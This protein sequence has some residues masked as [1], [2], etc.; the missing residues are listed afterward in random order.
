MPSLKSA[1]DD[2][3]QGRYSDAYVVIRAILTHAPSDPDAL[4]VAGACARALG[5]ATAA[6]HYWR[7]AIAARPGFGEALGNLGVL[8]LDC[9]RAEESVAVCQSAVAAKPT[10]VAAHHNFGRALAAVGRSAEAEAS[11]RSAVAIDRSCADAWTDLGV[12]LLDSGRP[13]DAEIAFAAAAALKPSSAD[14]AVNHAGALWALG[15]NSEAV[16][17]LRRALAIDPRNVGALANLSAALKANDDIDEAE[18]L[19]R[20]AVEVNPALAGLHWSLGGIL[21]TKGE[22]D[23][24][25]SSYRTAL[26]LAPGDPDANTNLGV[27]LRDRGRHVEAEALLRR[28]L[29]LDPGHAGARFNLSMV[30]LSTGRYADGWRAYEARSEARFAERVFAPPDFSFPPWRGESLAGK[31]I[32][33]LR[34]QGAGDEIQCARFIPILKRLGAAHVSLMSRPELSTLFARLGADRLIVEQGAVDLERH[35]Y[36]AFAFSV[37]GQLCP[38]ERSI[39]ASIPYL[40]ADT[41]RIEKWRSRLAGD[42]VKIGLVWKGGT[43]HKNDRHRSLSG[44]DVLKP[45]WAIAPATFF[46]LQKG[47]DENITA[48]LDQ[49]LVNLAPEIH[50]F[51]DTAAIVSQLDLVITVDTAVAHVAGAVGTETWVMIPAINADWRWPVGRADSPWYPGVM[52]V[53]RQREPGRWDDV[54]AEI[55]SA[56]QVHFKK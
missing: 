16:A 45:L 12:L 5:D 35:D 44:I 4:N 20:R 2:Y 32:L 41:T 47:R 23:E 55:A 36:W 9:G 25:E 50:D 13:S 26:Q 27:L 15:R 10:Q 19:L 24:A 39:P 52:R 18:S 8:L 3:S 14:A 30:L 28:A 29:E 37:A 6:E 42:G 48:P 34:E 56:A 46:S 49:P 7:A 1:I 51:A 33:V 21:H 31:S 38:D 17:A 43:I 22:L 53:F 54:V 11:Y 40:H